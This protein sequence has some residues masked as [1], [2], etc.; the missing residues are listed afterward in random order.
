[1]T[2]SFIIA[3]VHWPDSEGPSGGQSDG[4]GRP[5][6]RLIMTNHSPAGERLRFTGK[7]KLVGTVTVRIYT[8]R[9][10]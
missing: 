1:V 9:T 3:A 4:P 6:A 7:L 8:G 10:G 5:G 2:D